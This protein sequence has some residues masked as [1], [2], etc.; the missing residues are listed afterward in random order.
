MDFYS[1]GTKFLS[2]WYKCFSI[3]LDCKASIIFI[4]CKHR[5]IRLISKY[6][7]VAGEVLL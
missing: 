3:I 5:F 1:Y 4:C 6:I 7:T 2:F